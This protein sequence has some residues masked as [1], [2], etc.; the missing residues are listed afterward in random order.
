MQ[1]GRAAGYR[2]IRIGPAG[3]DYLSTVHRPDHEARDILD[4]ANWILLEALSGR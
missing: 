4:A 3:E 2:T 1:Q